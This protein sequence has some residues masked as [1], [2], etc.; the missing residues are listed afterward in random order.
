MILGSTSN[1]KKMGSRSLFLILIASPLFQ[2]CAK[3][4]VEKI[5]SFSSKTSSCLSSDDG[6]AAEIQELE[7]AQ[8]FTFTLSGYQVEANTNDGE[9]SSLQVSWS[10]DTIPTASQMDSSTFVLQKTLLP[11]KCDPYTVRASVSHCDT[12]FQL[13]RQ[14]FINPGDCGLIE[15]DPIPNP[16]IGLGDFRITGVYNSGESFV[17]VGEG[18]TI[19]APGLPVVTATRS[20][21][22]YYIFE[23]YEGETRI[24]QMNG[25]AQGPAPVLSFHPGCNLV[26]NKQY[27]VHIYTSNQTWTTKLMRAINNPYRFSTLPR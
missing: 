1:E 4:D 3:V 24:C 5:D 22:N 9:T 27:D 19:F 6:S 23:I 12:Q 13:E 15:E 14:L 17:G 21:N 20:T 26:P 18:P 25:L 2:G 7:S 16:E 11:P 10:V 8:A